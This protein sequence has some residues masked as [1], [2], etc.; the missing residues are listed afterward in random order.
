MPIKSKPWCAADHWPLSHWYVFAVYTAKAT[1]TGAFAVTRFN[2][3]LVWLRALSIRRIQRAPPAAPR[4]VLWADPRNSNRRW[5]LTQTT[6]GNAHATLVVHVE[7]D[8]RAVILGE[9]LDE[10]LRRVQQL[11]SAALDD[12]SGRSI[13]SSLMTSCQKFGTRWRCG[14]ERTGTRMHCEVILRS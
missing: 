9:V 6:D 2:Y 1:L 3:F 10:V 11:S 14:R 8:L 7:L 12:S 4:R 5:N 13:S